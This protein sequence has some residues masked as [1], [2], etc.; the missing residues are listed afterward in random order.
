MQARLPLIFILV[1]MVIDA[2]GIGLIIPVMPDLLREVSHGTLAEA[3]LWGGI[4]TTLYALMQ[5]A[6][7]PLIGNLSDRFGRRPVL[8]IS[9]AVMSVDYVVIALA[10]SIWVLMAGRVLG[11]VAA[12]TQSTATAFM[13]DISTPDQKAARFGLIG[14]AFGLGFVLGP[15]IGGLLAGYGTR[16]PFWAAA[17]LAAVNLVFGYFALPESLTAARRRAFD[18]RRANPFGALMH[19]GEIPGVTRLIVVFFLYQVA[20]FVYPSVWAYFGTE[21]FGWGPRMIG[22][23]LAGFGVAMAVVQGVLIGHVIRWLGERGTVLYGL[24]FNAV[25]FLALALVTDGTTALILT[26]LTALGAVVTPA[27]QGM[28]SRAVPDDAQGALQGLLTSAGAM[29]MIVSPF[30]M[31]QVFYAFTAE[32]TAFYLPGAPFLLSMALMAACA[33]V[34]LMRPRTVGAAAD[35][36]AE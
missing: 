4:L 6:C 36:P 3:A 28:M 5:F 16:A 33:A 12:A 30:V 18:W 29:A 2:M 27:L 14:A 35:R 7:G 11:G 15:V 34:F 19:M 9:L 23:S 24:A 13:A 8:L 17:A 22:L 25:A 31:T 26:P 1:T 32:R 10:G 21:R 20:F